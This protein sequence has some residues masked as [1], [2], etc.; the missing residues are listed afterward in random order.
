MEIA[1]SHDAIKAARKLKYFRGAASGFLI[2]IKLE[3]LCEFVKHYYILVKYANY[4]VY[5]CMKFFRVFW[6]V[7]AVLLIEKQLCLK[8]YIVIVLQPVH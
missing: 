5:E 2:K 4:N 1:Y 7:S 6:K 8:K 3:C